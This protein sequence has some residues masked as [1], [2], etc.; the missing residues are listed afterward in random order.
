[1]LKCLGAAKFS[2]S[3]FG[4]LGSASRT[5]ALKNQALRRENRASKCLL[6]EEDF[7]NGL[8]AFYTTVEEGLEPMVKLNKNMSVVRSNE[9]NLSVLL[10]DCSEKDWPSLNFEASTYE[11]KLM[12]FSPVNGKII[13]KFC[14]ATNTFRSE[15][16]DHD[17]L[18]I[19]TRDV[20]RAVK[21]SPRW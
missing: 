21:G 9:G 4:A 1:M 12:Y 2:T 6:S 14:K 5:R 19:L 8:S 7:S 15:D 11:K 13:Y 3:K 10:G 17:L 16:D 18:G 20:M